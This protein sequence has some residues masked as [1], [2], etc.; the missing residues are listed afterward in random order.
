M[1]KLYYKLQVTFLFKNVLYILSSSSHC[2]I[3]LHNT[4]VAWTGYVNPHLYPNLKEAFVKIFNQNQTGHIPKYS[5]N[6]NLFQAILKLRNPYQSFFFYFEKD[7]NFYIQ[8][9]LPFKNSKSYLWT[10]HDSNLQWFTR[11]AR[12]GKEILWT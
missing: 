6:W 10:T 5:H 11:E 8:I 2:L 12:H 3:T 1:T 4:F 9:Y 7:L